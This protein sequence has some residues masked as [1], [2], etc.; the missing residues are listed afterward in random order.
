MAKPSHDLR[1]GSTIVVYVEGDDG[2]RG[3]FGTALGHDG[4]FTVTKAKV[5][6]GENYAQQADGSYFVANGVNYVHDLPHG[7]ETQGG[8]WVW[9]DEVPAGV[10]V[11]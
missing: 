6:S 11:G 9:P 1:R 7:D 2:V 5:P 10:Y 4:Q 3:Y 8:T